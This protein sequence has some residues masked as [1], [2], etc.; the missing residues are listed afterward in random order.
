MAAPA[1]E[2]WGQ[3]SDEGA[4][5]IKVGPEDAPG[6]ILISRVPEMLFLEFWGLFYKILKNMKSAGTHASLQL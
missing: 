5:N 6:N 1:G 4:R 3:L 2:N